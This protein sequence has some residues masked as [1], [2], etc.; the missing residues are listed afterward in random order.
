MGGANSEVDE[1][2]TSII[3][4]SANFDMYVIRRTSMRHGLFTDAVTRYTKGQTPAQ[5][6]LALLKASE[7]IQE[8]LPRV[9]L[10]KLEDLQVE[11]FEYDHINL[12]VQKINN[13]LGLELKDVEIEEILNRAE[14]YS[15]E[16]GELNQI[17][18]TPPFWR[19][20]LQIEEDIIEEV[21][22]IYGFNNLPTSLTMRTTA[23]PHQNPLIK[24]KNEVRNFLSSRGANE[25]LTY[26]FVSSKLLQKAG[27]D[28]SQA[29][30]IR[31]AL[32]PDLQKYRLSL[33]PNL[34]DKVHQNIKSGFNEFALFE[35]GKTHV[36]DHLESESKSK[37]KLP[38]EFQRLSLVYANKNQI[39]GVPFFI[40]K[41]YL[42]ELLTS[43]NL[44]LKFTELSP[45]MFGLNIPI[46]SV[47]NSSRCAGV[48][49]EG[50]L[51]GVIG[52][53]SSDV[54][55]NFK[56][57]TSC[58]GFELDL[59]WLAEKYASKLNYQP[60]SS[61]PSVTQDVTISTPSSESYSKT[62]DKLK[63]GLEDEILKQVQD[64]GPGAGSEIKFKIHPVSI[65]QKS[66]DSNKPDDKNTTF[67]IEFWHPQR[68]L[69]T[70]EVNEI[71]AKL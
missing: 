64:D 36:K 20:D 67:S 30:T 35:I 65:F 6:L 61:F 21:G 23:P 37:F 71:L 2:T 25:V 3:I 26:N 14:I 46:T 10:S 16:M 15:H 9:K 42:T 27:Q 12:P 58:A 53:F 22:R 33:M 57:P 28:P 59:A 32:S 4:E 63:S 69:Q 66:A 68:T 38:A 62:L 50:E 1:N 48:E 18:V 40:A 51:R 5:T 49:I 56:L 55:K 44:N 41:K 19:T 13:L 43:L 31:N 34:L 60:L 54:A 8:L 39:S 24:L 70:K 11:E 29:F 45:E 7:V 47:Y 17:C 52:E